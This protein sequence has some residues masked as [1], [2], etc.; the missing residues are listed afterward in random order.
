[1]LI[2]LTAAVALGAAAPAPP[3]RGIQRLITKV[4]VEQGEEFSLRAENP[5][6]SPLS[7]TA[8]VELVL[9]PDPRNEEREPYAPSL[10]YHAPLD[11]SGDSAAPAKNGTL[12]EIEAL[13]SRAWTG[14]LSNLSWHQKEATVRSGAHP[15]P[16]VVPAGRYKL[17]FW[18]GGW[19]S[20]QVDVVVRRG[21]KVTP[22]GDDL[23]P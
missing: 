6:P 23:N 14:R 3:G 17:S 5:A 22:A 16:Q 20:N 8:A 4:S 9:T 2:V 13:S 1:M 19:R 18:I 10:S 21:G 11:L 15:L 7:S 12:L